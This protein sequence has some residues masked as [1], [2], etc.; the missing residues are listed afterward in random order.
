MAESWKITAYAPRPVIQAALLA[1]EEAWDW[2]FNIVLAGFEVADDQPEDWK[3]EAWLPRKPTKADKASITALF[4]GAAPQF[5]IELL[6]ETDW[7]TESQ[8]GI[9]PIRAGHFYVHTPD[10]PPSDEPD[11]CN[12]VIP[13][14]SLIHI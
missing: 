4:E 10:Y 2:D 9:E 1:H 14:L 11:T 13:A 5:H 7:V 6:P 12:F 8:K 3:L